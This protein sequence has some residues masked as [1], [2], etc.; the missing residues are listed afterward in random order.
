MTVLNIALSLNLNTC[1]KSVTVGEKK[2]LSIRFISCWKKKGG[3][4]KRAIA[5]DSAY[6]FKCWSLCS[7]INQWWRV[8][9]EG[10]QVNDSLNCSIT[11][12]YGVEMKNVPVV[13]LFRCPIR[14]PTWVRTWFTGRCEDLTSGGHL[15]NKSVSKWLCCSYGNWYWGSVG[16]G[17][18]IWW[19]YG[20]SARSAEPL[21]VEALLTATCFIC[22][23]GCLANEGHLCASWIF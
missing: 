6:R 10:F 22:L 20:Q 21:G 18:H 19:A 13:F 4:R 5:K 1:L 8:K 3:N 7:A 12:P 14:A 2:N 11:L 9:E 16:V 17:R 15:T 23:R